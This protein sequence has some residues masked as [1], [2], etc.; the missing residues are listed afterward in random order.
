MQ[1]KK[2][3]TFTEDVLKHMALQRMTQTQLAKYL[4][5]APS[6]VSRKFKGEHPWTVKEQERLRTLFPI[7]APGPEPSPVR[8]DPALEAMDKVLLGLRKHKRPDVYRVVALVTKGMQ[9]EMT[10]AGQ[11]AYRTLCALVG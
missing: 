6:S 7:A 10:P 5:I 2:Q 1:S 9:D 11:E 8:D 4:G 3:E